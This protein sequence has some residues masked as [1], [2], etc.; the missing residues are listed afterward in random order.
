MPVRSP[1]LFALVVAAVGVVQIGTPGAQAPA[2][3]RPMSKPA[4]PAARQVEVADDYHGVQ[5]ADPYRWLENAGDPSTIKWV[6]SQNALLRRMLDGP[7]RE[8]IRARLAALVDY[9][10]TG[11][12][13]RRGE[14]YFFGHNTGLQNQP[15]QFWSEGRTGEWR[16][17]ID[18]NMLS[19][20]GTVALTGLFVNEAGTLAAYAISRSGSDRQEI[21]VRDVSTGKD[22]PDR[23][24]WAKFASLAWL[25]DGSGFYYTRFPEPGSV[26]AGEE[27][28]GCKVYFHKLGD[29]QD[30]DALVFAHPDPEVV[31]GLD[32]ALEGRVLV[33][34]AVK[35]ASDKGEVHLLD[36]RVPDAEPVPLFRGFDH[37]WLPIDSA[38]L[39]LFL[40]TDHRA[41]RRRVVAVT[42]PATLAVRDAVPP[43]GDAEPAIE[44]ASI[45]EVVPESPDRVD[46]A[47]IFNNHLVVAYLHNAS[48]QVRLFAL[49]GRPRG[50]VT[51]PTL[52]TVTELS[53]R[54]QD[55][56]LFFS[57]TS[58]TSPPTPHRF[59]FVNNRPEPWGKTGTPGVDPGRYEVRQ[60]WY[61]SRDGTRVS[62]FLVAQKG[63]ALDGDRPVLLYGYGG[64]DISLTPA[65]SSS[66]HVWLERGGVYAVANLRG[67]GEYGDEWHR[68]GMLGSKQNVFDDFIAAAEW[69][70]A[71]GYTKPGR[72]AIQ[73]GSN[74]GL[75]TG[76]VMTQRPDLFG[77][78]V[79]QVPVA[80][81]L[82]YH[83]FT[84]GRYWIPEYGSADDPEQ[85]RFLIKYSPLHNVKDGTAYP[86]TLV[87]TA[88]TDDRVA[89]GMAK[90]FAARL[91]AATS[92]AAPVLIRVETKAGHG[93]G[94]PVTKVIDEQA[95]IYAFLWKVLGKT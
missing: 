36:R 51:L 21:L 54:P 70:V 63:L 93:A 30:K 31:F 39:R 80:D 17:L 68:G 71:N 84:V 57:F 15:V 89:P 47:A 28:Y 43:P 40:Q 27:N 35:G 38:G 26:P 49:D 22:L 2:R 10:R 69:L 59:N 75:L 52:G 56:D 7:D 74:G 24:K 13:V 72:L 8:A 6:G 16:T 86:A 45:E 88:D 90:K 66:L 4:Y 12:P 85:F 78:V 79:C 9:P 37:T 25:K 58:Y 64:F 95:D 34:A 92:G 20:D 19:A 48:S 65:F 14:R 53:A 87:T 3:P 94:K 1:V 18:P 29:T 41:P 5:V 81:M 55:S 83:R 46:A 62:M 23:L 76:A 67:G 77:A 44:G 60:V 11:V 73:G 33:I 50:E 91:Q 32:L 42:L 82:R 61:P